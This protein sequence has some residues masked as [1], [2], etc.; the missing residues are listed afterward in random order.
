MGLTVNDLL[1]ASSDVIDAA[2]RA[3]SGCIL[4]GEQETA[5]R[6]KDSPRLPKKPRVVCGRCGKR[7]AVLV[8]VPPYTYLCPECLDLD[9]TPETA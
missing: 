3:I 2:E 4:D 9:E 7:A 6:E 8:L 1:I 5:E